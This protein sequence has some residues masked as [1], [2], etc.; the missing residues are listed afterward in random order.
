MSEL[1][2][3]IARIFFD[4]FDPGLD[5]LR[6]LTFCVDIIRLPS[7]DWLVFLWSPSFKIYE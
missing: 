2:L 5:I 1:F 6:E 3:T 7:G 4:W